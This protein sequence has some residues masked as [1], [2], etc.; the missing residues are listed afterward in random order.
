[1]V[2]AVSTEQ[3]GQAAAERK[4][5]VKR[6]GRYKARAS[7]A[8]AVPGS[9]A[10]LVP[11]LVNHPEF[12]SIAESSDEGD[13]QDEDEKVR[14][15]AMKGTPAVP[16]PVAR[17]A[18]LAIGRN[19]GEGATAFLATEFSTD[20]AIVEDNTSDNPEV[21]KEGS[22]DDVETL[23]IELEFL[24]AMCVRQKAGEQ[25]PDPHP[26][27]PRF[28]S[29]RFYTKDFED[30]DR[31]Q[32]NVK[33]MRRYAIRV[34]TQTLRQ[35]GIYAIEAIQYA[36]LMA[37]DP[38]GTYLFGRSKWG[39]LFG[40]FYT[41]VPKFD[42]SRTRAGNQE[43]G[44]AI[45]R[46]FFQWANY[47]RRDVK[48]ITEPDCHIGRQRVEELLQ[49]GGWTQPKPRAVA[50]AHFETRLRATVEM[51]RRQY[52][53]DLASIEDPN[54]VKIDGLKAMYRAWSV[55]E[56]VSVDGNGMRVSRYNIPPDRPRNQ[57]FDTYRW[58]GAEVV[59]PVLPAQS[60]ATPASIEKV[61]GILRDNFRI[62]KPMEVS[63]GVHVH[64]GHKIGW[65][66]QQI[67][68]FVTL[69]YFAEDAL[70]YAHRKDRAAMERW[71]AKVGEK[72]RLAQALFDPNPETRMRMSDYLP[73]VARKT[74]KRNLQVMDEHI[75][76]ELIGDKRTEFVESVWE[77]TSI[78]DL[79][80]GMVG[81]IL[82]SENS[83]LVYRTTARI[84]IVGDKVSGRA[85]NI[86]P[87]TIEIR[88]MQGTLDATHI[89]HWIIILNRIMYYVR[90][91][92]TAEFKKTM[93]NITKACTG[94]TGLPS[95]LV[96][97]E[98]PMDTIKYFLD[99]S[100]RYYDQET[101][102]SWY[103]YPDL[104]K[105]NWDNPFMAPG[106]GPTHGDETVTGRGRAFDR[107]ID[108]KKF[109]I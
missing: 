66:L 19:A 85:T 87:N 6:L 28:L 16:V 46:R 107:A 80:A 100:R 65:N 39:K 72:T 33:K 55:T 15:L 70:I 71:C 43:V 42:G 8:R 56:D 44:N 62:H 95:L 59:S 21:C 83:T 51:L 53:S 78:D 5:V 38:M 81:G 104:D 18:S 13:N 58:F 48:R 3:Y 97:L 103:T 69:W 98:V 25:K 9:Y 102:A 11:Y 74:A 84:R 73:K 52:N 67:K 57:A 34:L 2:L 109:N 37:L 35:N 86:F 10:Q 22:E 93:D 90:R 49:E 20:R 7:S 68:R 106:S 4:K 64:L 45:L 96:Y 60:P 47:I 32:I 17:R 63:T 89:N 77:Y 94:R 23:G 36:D 76:L 40:L 26:D 75:D 105:V 1:M 79:V 82:Y 41:Q 108:A 54:Y 101:E 31:R 12:F 14:G 92:P 27:D 99:F 29:S 88:T 24:L 61:C 30:G 91:A 50:A